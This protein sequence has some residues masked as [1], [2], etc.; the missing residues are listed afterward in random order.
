MPSYDIAE[1]YDVKPKNVCLQLRKLGIIRP[2]SGPNSRNRN[3]KKKVYRSGYPVTFLPDH[4]RANHLGY[5]YDHV[6]VISEKLGYIP[7][8]KTP[9]HHID[10]DKKN[11]N[12][13]NLYLTH[14]LSCTTSSIS[15]ID[16]PLCGIFPRIRAARIASSFFGFSSQIMVQSK[17]LF[18]DFDNFD[19][20]SCAIIA[21]CTS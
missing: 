8:N 14:T 19:S 1:I 3:F 12:A 7:S 21:L 5:V 6:L 16:F 15:L 17:S 20:S 10:I 2:E 11:C 13:E 18:L 4:P 9:I